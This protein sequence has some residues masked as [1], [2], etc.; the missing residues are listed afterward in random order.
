ML[1]MTTYEPAY[2]EAVRGDVQR[3]IE[4]FTA[5]REAAGD[6]GASWAVDEFEPMFFNDQVIR[7]EA[8][9]VHRMRGREGKDGNTLNEVRVLSGSLL[10]NGGTLAIEKSI[11]WTPATTVLGLDAGDAI[12]LDADAFAR[13]AEAF[14]ID[15]ESKYR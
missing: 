1:S 15:L 13:L 7:L 8:A 9:F 2:I 12:A 5:L 3:R 4:A 11:K 14:L 10:E 6:A